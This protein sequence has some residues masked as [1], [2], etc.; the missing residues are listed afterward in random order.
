[1]SVAAKCTL[2]AHVIAHKA[3][4][5]ISIRPSN[6][7]NLTRARSLTLAMMSLDLRAAQCDNRQEIDP[8][9]Y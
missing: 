3:A 5:Q 7:D 8:L 2:P 9:E 4:F 1:V 6:G